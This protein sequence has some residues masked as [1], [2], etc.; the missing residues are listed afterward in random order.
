METG[1][2]YFTESCKNIT[3][4][5]T[6]TDGYILS[7]ITITIADGYIPSVF[8]REFWD[9]YRTCHNHR[10]IFRRWLPLKR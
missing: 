6:I 8:D 1:R 2:R 7:V 10:R 3:T 9:I 4:D 5:A